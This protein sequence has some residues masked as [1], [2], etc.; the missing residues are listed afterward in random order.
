MKPSPVC[1]ASLAVG[2]ANHIFCDQ[3]KHRIAAPVLKFRSS[4][5]L[6]AGAF[7][8]ILSSDGASGTAL[9]TACNPKTPNRASPCSFLAGECWSVGERTPYLSVRRFTCNACKSC[10]AHNQG[11]A[12]SHL[13]CLQRMDIP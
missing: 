12:C 11:P 9:E 3:L 1:F 4:P 8:I 2:N 7:F 10:C 6:T 5:V 13:H